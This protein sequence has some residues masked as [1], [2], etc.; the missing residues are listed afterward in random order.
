MNTNR[1]KYFENDKNK[2]NDT[3]QN[4]LTKQK[5]GIR[6]CSIGYGYIP[7]FCVGRMDSLKITYFFMTIFRNFDNLEHYSI[8]AKN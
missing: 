4:T 6:N 8:S 2:I 5:S 7:R 3:L 1:D